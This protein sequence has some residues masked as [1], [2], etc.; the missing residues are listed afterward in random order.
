[1]SPG[2]LAF[3][4]QKVYQNMQGFKDVEILSLR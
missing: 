1:M 2:S 4:M 3:Q